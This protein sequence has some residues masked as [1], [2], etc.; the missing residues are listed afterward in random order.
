MSYILMH[1]L[2]HNAVPRT[3]MNLLSNNIAAIMRAFR[4][5]VV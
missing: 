1:F 4:K 2:Q 3:A 5:F